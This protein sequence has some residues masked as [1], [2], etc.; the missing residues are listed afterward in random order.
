M[1]AHGSLSIQEYQ[2]LC[3]DTNRR[4]LQRDLKDMLEKGLLVE[5]GASSTDP[6]KRYSL[7][8]D[9]KP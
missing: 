5:K 6:T 8:T 1:L 2:A 7:A 3:P 4:T 9:D